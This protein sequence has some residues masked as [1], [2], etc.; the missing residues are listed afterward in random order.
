MRSVFTARTWLLFGMSVALQSFVAVTWLPGPSPIDGNGW[1]VLVIVV[2]FAIC[3][4][5]MA[6]LIGD[7]KSKKSLR[8]RSFLGRDLPRRVRVT[9]GLLIAAALLSQILGL[10]DGGGVLESP[11]RSGDRYYAL[12]VSL[13]PRVDV[14]IPRGRYEFEIE[15]DQRAMLGVMGLLCAWFTW[16]DLTQR[17]SP[18]RKAASR[19]APY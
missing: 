13:S 18:R 4:C 12:N 15:D 2:C 19:R 3:V 11:R 1:P 14:E 7:R 10:F 5:A 17:P 8:G 16:V 9:G 6:P